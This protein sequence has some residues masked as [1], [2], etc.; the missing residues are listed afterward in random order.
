MGGRAPRSGDRG[1]GPTPLSAGTRHPSA[2]LPGW[3]STGTTATTVAWAGLGRLTA[4]GRG[5]PREQ[6]VTLEREQHVAAWGR[7]MRQSAWGA[8]GCAGTRGAGQGEEGPSGTT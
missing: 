2:G 7:A 6:I 5:D 3:P 1:R 4:R 8:G